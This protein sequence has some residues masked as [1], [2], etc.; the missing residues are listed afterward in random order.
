MPVVSPFVTVLIFIFPESIPIMESE[1]VLKERDPG[2]DAMLSQMVG[3][4]TSKPGG[5]LE[6]G[7]VKDTNISYMLVLIQRSCVFAYSCAELEINFYFVAIYIR[8]LPQLS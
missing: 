6:L 8:V 5:K 4:I 7:K 3:R 1:N 2:Y